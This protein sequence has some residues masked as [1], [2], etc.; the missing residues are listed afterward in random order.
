LDESYDPYNL[1]LAVEK[2][3]EVQ[4]EK[5]PLGVIFK[6][7]KNPYHEHIVQLKEPL[8]KRDRFTKFESLISEFE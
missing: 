6:K 1:T 5:F 3:L 4:D 7:E 8:A 2:S